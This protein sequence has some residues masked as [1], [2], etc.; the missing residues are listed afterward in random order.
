MAQAQD[1][2]FT[3]HNLFNLPSTLLTLSNT[4]NGG[5]TEPLSSF[6]EFFETMETVKY[7]K[8]SF[9]GLSPQVLLTVLEIHT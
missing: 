3:P 8:P 1:T 9:L 2:T 7:S 4:N 6:R 5:N